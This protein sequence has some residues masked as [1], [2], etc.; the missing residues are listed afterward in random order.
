MGQQAVS[1]PARTTF[2][3]QVRIAQYEHHLPTDEQSEGEIAG[4]ADE[5]PRVG[6]CEAS[7]AG[8]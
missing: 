4:V 2:N 6:R 1:L 8:Q 3:P 7:C 5:Y